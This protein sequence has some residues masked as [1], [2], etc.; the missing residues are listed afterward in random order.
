MISWGRTL[1]GAA[2]T[3]V[4]AAV[5]VIAVKRE[6][7]PAVL[8][9]VVASAFVG[10]IAWNAIL[11]R[12]EARSFFVDVPFDPFPVSWQDTGSSVFA[13]AFAAVLVGLVLRRDN[14]ADVLVLAI[15]VAVVALVVDV[16]FY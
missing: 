10:P 3:T 13:L 8:A 7:R 5:A 6:R 16:Y 14:A 2:L 15:V 1:Y 11:H 4:V 12:T 9:A